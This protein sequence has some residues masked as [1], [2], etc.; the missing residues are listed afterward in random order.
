MIPLATLQER[1]ARTA[2]HIRGVSGSEVD[3]VAADLVAIAKRVDG[4]TRLERAHACMIDNARGIPSSMGGGGTPTGASDPTGNAIMTTDA[5]TSALEELD[6][7]TQLMESHARNLVLL[8][9]PRLY[10]RNL[11][12]ETAH[13]RRIV[14]N[15]DRPPAVRW[16]THCMKVNAYRSTVEPGRYK[17]VCRRCGDWKKINGTLPPRDVLGYLQTNEPIPERVLQR[18]HAIV[19]GGRTAR[20]KRRKRK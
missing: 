15:W 20:K 17:D 1:I 3:A 13:V 6:R 16:C 11:M 12:S 19:P 10:A 2:T 14:E 7:S 8:S 5:A 4:R 18:H 9:E